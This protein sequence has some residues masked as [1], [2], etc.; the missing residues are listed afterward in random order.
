MVPEVN[1]SKLKIASA[2]VALSSVLALPAWSADTNAPANLDA[3]V[4]ATGQPSATPT[5]GT[6]GSNSGAGGSRATPQ[7]HPPTA[8]MDT[9]TP[10]DKSP[11]KAKAAK[12]PPT[13]QMDSAA[14]DQKSPATSSAAQTRAPTDP[15]PK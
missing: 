14:P 2:V 8:A 9:A 5:D 3:Q 12:H 11:T 1:M 10:T 4:P 15:M 6:T 7:K 13:G